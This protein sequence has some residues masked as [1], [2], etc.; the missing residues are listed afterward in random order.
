LHGSL[1]HS[2][3][4]DCG[5]PYKASSTQAGPMSDGE[6]VAPP[7]CSACGHLVR[8]G[9]VWFGEALPTK[10]W[11]QALAH[12]AECGVFLSVGTSSV[13]QPAAELPR[14]ARQNG[15]RLVQINPAATGLEPLLDHNLVG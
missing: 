8:P 13:V 15:A 9:V 4:S 11:Q 3:C 5:V 6:R 12:A 7:P 10:P 1:H 2:Y 14:I